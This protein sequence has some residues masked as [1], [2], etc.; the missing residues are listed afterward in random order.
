MTGTRFLCY[1]GKV[2][3]TEIAQIYLSPT[4]STH[5]SFL[6]HSSHPAA[7]L[8]PHRLGVR[9]DQDRHHALLCGAVR[10]LQPQWQRSPVE[11]RARNIHPQSGR[12]LC[13]YSSA[14]TAHPTRLRSHQTLARSLLL[15]EPRVTIIRHLPYSGSFLRSEIEFVA[16]FDV[17]EIIPVVSVGYDTVDALAEQGVDILFFRS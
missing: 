11:H 10:F 2:A 5:S 12:L 9:T 3:A 17:E 4:D 13:R 8:R 1:P 14:A 7:G 6:E 15:R 16:S